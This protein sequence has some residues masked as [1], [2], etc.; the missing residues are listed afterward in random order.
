MSCGV[1]CRCGSDLVWLWRRLAATALIQ[2]VPWEPPYAV[3]S[4]LKIDKQ[5]NKIKLDVHISLELLL[6]KLTC[7]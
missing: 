2:P 6:E 1:A 4:A 5:E 7:Q 3:G